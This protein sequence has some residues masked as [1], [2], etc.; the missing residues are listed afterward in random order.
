[1]SS[2]E[3][4]EVSGSIA[5]FAPGKTLLIAGDTLFGTLVLNGRD[6]DLQYMEETLT[7]KAAEEESDKKLNEIQV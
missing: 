3:A 2:H 6:N 5:E 1:M 4:Y 7:Q